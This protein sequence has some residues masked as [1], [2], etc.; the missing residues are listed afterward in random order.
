MKVF[1]IH[2]HVIAADRERYPFDGVHG[3]A[4][5]FIDE[6]PVT[7]E[8]LLAQMDAAGIEHAALVQ[9]SLA[10]GYDNRYVADSAAAYPGRFAAVCSVDVRAADAPQ[11]LRYWIRER[12]MDGL[13]V[14]ASFGTM[15]QSSDWLADPQTA[16]AWEAALELGIPVCVMMKNDSFPVLAT[17]LARYPDLRVVLDHLGAPPTDDGPPFHAAGGLWSL[18]GHR[19][20]YLKL[21]SSVLGRLAKIG[22]SAAFVRRVIDCFGADRIAWGSNVPTSAGTLA[23]LLAFAQ[24]QL[25]PLSAAEREAIF[26]GTARSL[27]PKFTARVSGAARSG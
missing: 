9:M 21:T 4:E 25:A 1:D 6:R 22:A 12:G 15:A 16:P 17:V 7:T 8:Q 19:N 18:A 13:R 24:D 27:Y 11:R 26:N 5:S 10:Y 23:E 3:K 20:L 2:P 14:F